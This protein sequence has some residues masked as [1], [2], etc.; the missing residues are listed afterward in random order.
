MNFLEKSWT[1]FMWI[2]YIE[3]IIK[4]LIILKKYPQFI[5]ELNGY[6]VSEELTKRREEYAKKPFNSDIIKEF[7]EIFSLDPEIWNKPF[8]VIRISRN[9][10]WHSR[11]SVNEEKLWHT[12]DTERRL[13]ELKELFWITWVWN[14]VTIDDSNFHFEEKIA[15][16]E[17]LDK[18]FFPWIAQ[19]IWLDYERI[20]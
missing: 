15:M 9:I 8:Q 1:Y 10:F 5:G 2:L 6:I 4:D 11:I 17:K 3:G 13:S 16:I 18:E 20:R 7:L 12:P 14:N 19:T